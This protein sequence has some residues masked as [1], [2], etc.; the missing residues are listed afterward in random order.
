MDIRKCARSPVRLSQRWWR[1]LDQQRTIQCWSSFVLLF[2]A[3][4]EVSAVEL[5]TVYEAPYDEATGTGYYA[6]ESW[7]GNEIRL[8]AGPRTLVG[9]EFGYSMQLNASGAVDVAARIYANDGPDGSPLSLLWESGIYSNQPISDEGIIRF[10][11]PSLNVPD[12]LT[13]MTYVYSTY[14]PH[15]SIPY[16]LPPAY[17][18]ASELPPTVGEADWLWVH[19]EIEHLPGWGRFELRHAL[20]VRILAVPEPHLINL[21]LFGHAWLFASGFRSFRK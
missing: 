6:G 4:C 2:I 3:T 20:S 1:V 10:D 5:K 17:V 11:I 7:V 12:V 21:A 14:V 15:P 18:M 13:V 16:P 8:A 9:I 19:R